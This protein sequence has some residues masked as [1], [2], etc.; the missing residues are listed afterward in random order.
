[1]KPLASVSLDLDNQWSYMKTHGDAGWETFPSYLDEF[2]PYVLDALERL[3]LRITFFLVGQDAALDR[4]RE[5]LRAVA[6]AGH[7][8][9]NHS[10]HHEQW[11]ETFSA[12]RIEREV[13]EAAD[14]IERATGKRPTGYRG[15]GFSWNEELLEVLARSGYLYDAST[16]P[17]YIGPLARLYY[18]RT[19]SIAREEMDKRKNLFGGFGDGRRPVRPYLWKLR[20]G[21]ALLEIPVTTIPIV[22]TPFHLSYLLYLSRFSTLLMDAY[23]G[24]AILAC[25]ATRTQPSF[26]LHPLD[27]IGG[28]RVRELAFFPGMDVGSERKL[29]VFRRVLRRLSRRFDLVDMAGHAR[30][31]LARE[32][33]V[34]DVRADPVAG[35]AAR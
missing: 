8:V 27:L 25:R 35:G 2:V 26:L 15:P 18:F 31:A 20:S 28:D 32:L 4:N 7:D 19:A 29:E 16:L 1:M 17:T 22:K 33:P 12:Q 24:L 13:V 5:S 11:I 30:D 3:G 6:D 10:F 9:G 34:R 21:R 23:L 14:A